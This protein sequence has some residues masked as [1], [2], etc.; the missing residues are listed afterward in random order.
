MRQKRKFSFL[1]YIFVL[2]LLTI[3]ILISTTVFQKKP[4]SLLIGQPLA[5]FNL[6]DEAREILPVDQ[7][8]ANPLPDDLIIKPGNYRVFE[9]T[10]EV[11]KEGLYRFLL[12]SKTNEQRIVFSSDIPA[13]MSAISWIYSHG[14]RDNGLNFEVLSRKAQKEKLVA[15]C[16]GISNF[17]QKTLSQKGIESRIV[18]GLTQ[19]PYNGYDDSHV[20]VEVKVDGRWLLYDLDNNANFKKD[21][22]YLN[23]YDFQKLVLKSDFEIE[24]LSADTGLAILGF[25]DKKTGYDYSFY[26]EERFYSEQALRDWYKHVL[27]IAFIKDGNTY[28]YFDG[29]EN[30]VNQFQKNSHKISQDEF[31]KKFY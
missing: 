22:Q 30:K 5:F 13:L 26:Q 25:E 20:M 4:Q 11:Q 15:T 1:I 7:T 16:G 8:D 29:D 21:G 9:T 2:F 14:T 27:Q 24:K 23:Y 31:L 3:L 17:I 28:Y 19:K 10:Y 6:K 18:I 12:P